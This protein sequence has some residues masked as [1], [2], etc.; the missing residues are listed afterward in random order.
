MKIMVKFFLSGDIVVTEKFHNN[1]I[2][3][4]ELILQLSALWGVIETA[5]LQ[6]FISIG[7]SNVN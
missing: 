7:P 6:F 2:E 1:V 4:K 5:L 3:N